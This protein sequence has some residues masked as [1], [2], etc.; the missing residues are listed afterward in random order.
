[1]TGLVDAALLAVVAIG[2]ALGASALLQ[3]RW[4]RRSP[5]AAILLWQA[6]GLASGLAAVGT[7]IGLALPARQAG[8]RFFVLRAAGQLRDGDGFGLARLFGLGEA[9]GVPLVLVAVR[10]AC[11]AAGLLLLASLCWV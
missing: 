8:L 2:S 1:M 5:A 7:L 6:L 4:P 11:L 3:A 10:L 9:D